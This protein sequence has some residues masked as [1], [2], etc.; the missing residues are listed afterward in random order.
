MYRHCFC[1]DAIGSRMQYEAEEMCLHG[2][3]VALVAQECC[4]EASQAYT[5][6]NNLNL[7][8]LVEV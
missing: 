3:R 5:C 2:I 7:D 8:K 1:K 4:K 6:I